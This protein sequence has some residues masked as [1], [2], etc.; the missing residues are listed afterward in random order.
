MTDTLII[1]DIDI[2]GGPPVFSGTRV[3]IAI[4]IEHLDA[5]D[6]LDEILDN[7]PTVSRSQAIKVLETAKTILRAE[8]RPCGSGPMC[9]DRA[10]RC[11]LASESGPAWMAASPV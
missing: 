1:K 2:L 10:A 8:G 11:M 7:Y 9:V 6:W 3:P 4:L 5:G